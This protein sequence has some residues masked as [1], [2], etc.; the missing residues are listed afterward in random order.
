[1]VNAAVLIY[2]FVKCKT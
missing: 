2:L 1:M